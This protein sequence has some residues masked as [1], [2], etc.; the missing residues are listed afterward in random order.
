MIPR[1]EH[2]NKPDA[3]C[4]HVAAQE[5]HPMQAN[6][7]PVSSRQQQVHRDLPRLVRRHLASHW[8][9]PPRSL[10]ADVRD[11]L[12]EALAQDRPLVL[13]SFCGTGHSTRLL[14]RDHPDC[15][16][17]G[18]DKSTARLSRHGERDGDNYWLLRAQCE[19]VWAW[20]AGQGAQLQAH[21]LLYPN[22]WPKPAQLK[23]RVHGHPGFP[24]LVKL[25]GQLELRCNWQIYA[26]EFG[27]A[28]A[29]AGQQPAVAVIN[30]REPLSLFERKYR[31]S[32]HTLWCCTAR[33]TCHG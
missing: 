30:D 22:P 15:T 25:G 3:A 16:V 17:I 20:L 18:V 23:R 19:E 12:A 32:G 29:I 11:T 1:R 5:V 26:E 10:T 6:S 9:R 8:Q 27:V 4:L 2:G 13:D 14:A 24:L 31:D 21:Y 28:L 7:R 33:V